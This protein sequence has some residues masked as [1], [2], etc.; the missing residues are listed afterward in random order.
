M[1]TQLESKHAA[2]QHFLSYCMSH[3]FLFQEYFF[4]PRANDSCR[5]DDARLSARPDL[6]LC[7]K[8]RSFAR[9]REA[10][11]SAEQHAHKESRSTNPTYRFSIRCAVHA[12]KTGNRRKIF[13]LISNV[14]RLSF[15]RLKKIC[16]Q[17]FGVSRTCRIPRA[18]VI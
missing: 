8:V 1:A 2:T 15:P 10:P 11:S 18:I 12:L 6:Q 17:H 13:P 3:L 14:V 16:R 4:V 7:A 9:R 5:T